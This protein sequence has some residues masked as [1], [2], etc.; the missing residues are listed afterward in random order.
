MSKIKINELPEI[1]YNNVNDDDICIIE[2][3][4][5]TYKIPVSDLKIIFSNDN[6]INGI[7]SSLLN[8]INDLSL[9]LAENTNKYDEWFNKIEYALNE[10]IINNIN[11]LIDENIKI[12]QQLENNKNDITEIMSLI[13]GIN[14]NINNINS[15]IENLNERVQLLENDNTTNKTN[16]S[17]NTNNISTNKTNISNNTKDIEQL[18]KDLANINAVSKESITELDTELKELINQKY[19]ELLKLIDQYGHL[20]P[21][22]I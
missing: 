5:D 7:Y 16:I 12:K 1:R 13:T 8:R 10:N 2:N 19:D 17:N 20:N 14:L 11:R 9:S 6:K 15:A 21:I 18:K 4:Q 3:F 22:L